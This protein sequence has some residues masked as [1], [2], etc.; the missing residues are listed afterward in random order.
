MNFVHSSSPFG[1]ESFQRISN[2]VSQS[3]RGK[4]KLQTLTI[5]SFK[6]L[7]LIK[8]NKLSN[9]KEFVSLKNLLSR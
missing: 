1:K 6:I 5:N 8:I 3:Y 9:L 7:R 2:F 4:Q